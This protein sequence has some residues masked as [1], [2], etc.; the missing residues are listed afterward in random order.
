M[1]VILRKKNGIFWVQFSALS[2][3]KG[4]WH[5]IFTRSG[6]ISPEPFASLNVGKSNGDAIKNTMI[7]RK[8]IK[9]LLPARKVYTINQTHSTDVLQIPQDVKNDQMS[10]LNGDAMISRGKGRFLMIQV[11]DC[12]AILLADPVEEVVANVHSGWKGSIGDILGRTVTVM[13]EKYYCRPEHIV[14]GVGP[15][16]GPC[17]AEFKHYRKE[18]PGKYWSYK[19]NQDHFDFWAISHD[20]LTAAGLKD[21]NIHF[22]RICT[23]CNPHLFFSYRAQKR[24]GRF[25]AV[26]GLTRDQG[27]GI[28]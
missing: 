22:S 28:Q 4:V 7:N 20:Q 17:C 2:A 25:A 1:T 18:I 16:L 24:T 8:R 9:D 15:S 14:A 3:I 27:S 6:G 26:I 19:D 5:G 13:I 12:Q 10:S 21:A 11:A 23:R